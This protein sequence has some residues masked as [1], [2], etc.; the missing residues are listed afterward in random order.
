M[1]SGKLCNNSFFAWKSSLAASMDYTSKTLVPF[2][3]LSLCLHLFLFF[4]WSKPSNV[5]APPAQ[6]PISFLPPPAPRHD[7]TPASKPAP[8]AR[9]RNNPP[10]PALKSPSPAHSSQKQSPRR[11]IK[12]TAAL[13]DKQIMP[14]LE[15]EKP[16]RREEKKPAPIPADFAKTD[17]SSRP[18]P[19]LKELLPPAAWSSQRD[20]TGDREGPISL[21]T[22]EPRYL[23]YFET[24]KHAIE[25]VWEY[26]ELALRSGLDGKLILEFTILEDGEMVGPRLIHSSGFLELDQE[27]M[28]AV[29]AA[30]PFKP[31][32]ASVGRNRIDILASFEYSDN[33]LHYRPRR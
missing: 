15:A 18:L 8:A 21:N 20:Q 26:P 4:S 22:R 28:R 16:L 5:N 13:E 30:S 12:Q 14:P 19:S 23:T 24:V 10:A 25:Q 2:F 6:I 1:I 32:P 31:I 27:A 17:L 33:R 11:E 3:L 7:S 29:R 9:A